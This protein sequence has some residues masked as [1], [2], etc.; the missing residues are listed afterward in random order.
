ML[1]LARLVFVVLIAGSV[2]VV[3]QAPA[4]IADSGVAVVTD[5]E[6]ARAQP[7]RSA[8]EVKPRRTRTSTMARRGLWLSGSGHYIPALR[9]AF[10]RLHATKRSTTS[11]PGEALSF[12]T[13]KRGKC[14]QEPPS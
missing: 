7:G 8:V 11:C 3:G 5:A 13:G 2:A 9:A 12:R 6:A 4:R 10:I 1:V 14:P